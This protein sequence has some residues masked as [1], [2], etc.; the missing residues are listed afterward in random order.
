LQLATLPVW[1]SWVQ[2]LASSQVIG[3]EVGGSQVSPASIT[4]LPQVAEQ[5]LS[6]TLV[7]PL[8]Q[9]PSPEWQISTGSCV[10]ATLQLA[11]L[12]VR[13]SAVQALPSSQLAGQVLIGSQVSP[14]STMPFPHVAEQSESLAAVQPDGQQPSPPEQAAMGVLEHDTLQVSALP[15]RVSAVQSL[16]SDTQLEGHVDDGSQVSVP[17]IVPSPQTALPPGGWR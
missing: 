12:P 13:L 9:Q 17:S 14:G 6:L 15:L 1:V 7:Q 8:G 5:S 16:P 2:A 3:H 10:Q 4:P 11:S